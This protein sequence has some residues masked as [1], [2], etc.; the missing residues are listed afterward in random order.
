MKEIPHTFYF[1]VQ[2]TY[3]GPWIPALAALW[4][5]FAICRPRKVSI[6]EWLLA[7]V[8][9]VFLVVFSFTA[10]TS[11]RYYLPIA[12]T[13]CYLAA[14]ASFNGP[15]WQVL[16]R[17]DLGSAPPFSPSCC[18]SGPDGHSGATHGK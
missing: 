5:A 12:V 16:V 18:A 6:A 17:N 14:R 10:K 9:L 13:L 8:S 3:G 7:G 1:G 4:L 15:R 2:D 11:Q